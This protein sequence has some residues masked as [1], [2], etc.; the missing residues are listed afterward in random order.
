MLEHDIRLMDHGL[1]EAYR[2]L[3]AAGA[4]PEREDEDANGLAATQSILQKLGV[5]SD[6]VPTCTEG[7]CSTPEFG[8]HQSNPVD[9]GS[10]TGAHC[11]PI[12]NQSFSRDNSTDINGVYFERTPQRVTGKDGIIRAGPIGNTARMSVSDIDMAGNNSVFE[13]ST[14]MY[15]LDPSFGFHRQED[16][17][18]PDCFHWLEYASDFATSSWTPGHVTMQQLHK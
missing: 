1:Q 6:G 4:W 14:D 17:A 13:Q 5:A 9:S 12:H 11:D 8:E 16:S 7:F 18:N 15:G 10:T 2:R 3:V